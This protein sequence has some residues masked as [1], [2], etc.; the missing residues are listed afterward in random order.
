MDDH[1][2]DTFV[3]L[4]GPQGG[5]F[6]PDF[7]A[8]FEKKIPFFENITANAMWLV[9]YNFFGQKISVANIWR[10]PHHLDAYMKGNVFLPK[11]TT[12]ATPQMR[13]N[14]VRLKKAVFCIGSGRAYDGG[15]EPWQG[16]V[17]GSEDASG[18][19]LSMREQPY[20]A[21]DAFGLKTLDTSG[22]LNLTIV[23]GASHGDWTGNEDIIRAHVL[24]HCT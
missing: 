14:F 22:R 4:A 19:M 5:V 7:F 20:Y 18:K 24:P 3:L 15:I 16:G 13:S 8:S 1:K 12:H 17:F 10:D 9:A 11:Y 23:P 21:S 2:V 6:G